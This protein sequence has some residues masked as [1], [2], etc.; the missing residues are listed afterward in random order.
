MCAPA[1]ERDT[2]VLTRTNDSQLTIEI[3]LTA[4]I[5]PLAKSILPVP[6]LVPDQKRA[7]VPQRGS[8]VCRKIVRKFSCS[9]VFHPSISSFEGFQIVLFHGESRE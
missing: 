6:P 4:W 3:A 7:P 1:H 9:G 8:T 2:K 5:F